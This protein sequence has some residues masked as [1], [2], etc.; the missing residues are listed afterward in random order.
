MPDSG[1]V[2]LTGGH[3]HGHGHARVELYTEAGAA[4][5]L[6]SL[7]GVRWSHACG[8]FYNGDDLVSTPVAL[9]FHN[10]SLLPSNATLA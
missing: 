8:Y 9:R 3:T 7:N 2:V 5:Q 10:Q 6:P 1:A 4:Q